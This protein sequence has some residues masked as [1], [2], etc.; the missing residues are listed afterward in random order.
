MYFNQDSFK[1]NTPLEFYVCRPNNQTAAPIIGCENDSMTLKLLDISELSFEVPEYIYLP[2][3]KATVLNP[4]F[5]YLSQYMRIKDSE[6]R[7]F[8]I[9]AEPEIRETPDGRIKSVS[10]D[11]L[12]CELQDKDITALAV[13]MG[14]ELSREWYSENLNALGAPI[15][16]ITFVNDKEPRL[17]L[18]HILLEYAPN[19]KIG[20]VDTELRAMRRS[21]EI[22][23]S[24]LY[25]ILTQNVARAFEC[26]FLF[27]TVSRT[28][29]AYKVENIGEDT[30]IYLSIHNLLANQVITPSSDNIYTQFSVLADDGKDILPFANFGS[31]TISNYDYFL[32]PIWF[33]EETITKYKAY[34]TNVDAKR[35]RYME[36]TKSWNYLNAQVTELY[37]RVPDSRCEAAWTDLTPEELNAELES[38]RAAAALLR[39]LHTTDGVLQI[40][41]SSDYGIYVSLTEVIIPK[42]TAQI[43]AVNSGKIKPDK[44]LSWETN[45][46]LY[47]INE[48]NHLLLTYTDAVTLYAA[49]TQ[50]YD[51]GAH[52]ENEAIYNLNHQLYLENAEYVRQIQA[53][54]KDRKSRVSELQAEMDKLQSERKA[55]IAYAQMPNPEH[56]FTSEELKTFESLTVHTDY[57][58]ENILVT[59]FDDTIAQVDLAEK[60]YAAACEQLAIESRPQLSMRIDLDSFLSITKYNSFT[61]ELAVG[62]FIRV[63]MNSDE[64]EKLRI[65]SIQ[66]QPSDLSAKLNL[67]FSNMITTYNRRDD[68]TYLT[69]NGYSRSGKNKITAGISSDDLTTALSALLN[70][71]FASFTSSPV[72]QNAT[73]Q[74]I[75]AVLGTFDVALADYLKT[76]DL[77]AEVADISKLSADSAFITYLQSQFASLTELDAAK[78]DVEQLIA[79]YGEIKLLLSGSAATGSLHTI[80]LN[81]QNSVIDTAYI[82]DL[83]VQNITV[84]DLKAGNINTDYIG[85]AS[86]DGTLSINGATMQFSDASGVRLQLGRDA[87]GNFSFILRGSE[88]SVLIDENGLHED[89]ITDGLIK[90]RMV[91]D[92]AIDTGKVDWISAGAA[93][94]NGKPVWKSGS[95]TVN[96]DGTTLTEKISTIQTAIDANTGEINQLISDT[97]ITKEDGTTVSVKDDYNLTKDTVGSHA[98]ILSSHESSISGV[99]SKTNILEQDLNSTKN[100]ISSIKTNLEGD[101]SSLEERTGILE[102]NLD[103]FKIGVESHLEETNENASILSNM[104]VGKI[105]YENP[106]FALEN[107]EGFLPEHFSEYFPGISLY[108]CGHTAVAITAN[109]DSPIE[110]SLAHSISFSASEWNTETEQFIGGF[111]FHAA[112][113][114]NG[115]YVC[116]IIAKI[117]VDYSLECLEITAGANCDARWIGETKTCGDMSGKNIGVGRWAEYDFYIGCGDTG[118]FGEMF[119][120]CLT[121]NSSAPSAAY[122][123]SWELCFATVYDITNTFSYAQK[124]NHIEAGIKAQKDR[125]E[126]VISDTMVTVTDYGMD[127]TAAEREISVKEMYNRITSSIDGTTQIISDITEKVNEGDE[128]FQSIEGQMTTLEESIDNVSATLVNYPKTIDDKINSSMASYTMTSKAWMAKFQEALNAPDE[129]GQIVGT[130]VGEVTISSKGIQ[131]DKGTK[132]SVFNTDEINV[133]ENENRV[134]GIQEDSVY[135]NRLLAPNGADFYGIKAVPMQISD[136]TKFLCFVPSGGDS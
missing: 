110:D 38:C 50:P 129:N 23:A 130:T 83:M 80:Y 90:T 87:A 82:K 85:L 76:K 95:I 108:K 14:N 94:E 9:N 47:G 4:C 43:E 32:N 61:D 114:C 17:S 133:Y 15:N 120:F 119:H 22:D 116:K 27:D 20:H 86:D 97:T 104:A 42:L 71:K 126:Q 6:G 93:E 77:S 52:R 74:N 65:I 34:K 118:D 117:P 2:Q 40:E 41:D 91:E 12:E 69:G 103:S 127:G 53:A 128:K 109:P 62:N 67:E 18:M 55:L 135:T 36:L 45:W 75:Q 21:F 121:S 70:S 113:R 68:Y 58:N 100:N 98:Q 7:I 124:L 59:D 51:S 112:S 5:N 136:G 84:N 19:W 28:I 105:L 3:K 8:R 115:R 123:V 96:E 57:E 1:H 81:A 125:I 37:D 64:A 48:L 35:N 46:D 31:H 56:G 33:D 122:P 132:H 54:I 30:H 29:S 79:D 88:Q 72:F 11:S 134:F 10:A 102:L 63:G 78:I 73:A 13:N 24:D 99:T 44:E 106:T 49:Y 66:F 111:Y 101:I 60:L 92:N 89:A 25:A 39:E 16:Y 107:P 131:F 26:V